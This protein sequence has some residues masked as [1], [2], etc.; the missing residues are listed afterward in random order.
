LVEVKTSRRLN[1]KNLHSAGGSVK[2]KSFK[3]TAIF[4]NKNEGF[5]V[6]I[7]FIRMKPEKTAFM[8]F[9]NLKVSSQ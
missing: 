7:R 3:K 5:T 4:L 9:F 8:V 6:F 2:N 1:N